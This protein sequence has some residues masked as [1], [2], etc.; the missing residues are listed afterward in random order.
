MNGDRRAARWIAAL[1]AAVLA[2]CAGA[3]PAAAPVSPL[4]P[5]Q[6][7]PASRAWLPLVMGRGHTAQCW[8]LD[9]WQ[10]EPPAVQAGRAGEGGCG[11]I[12]WTPSPLPE[13][14]WPAC[15]SVEECER[16]NAQAIAKARPG[17]VVLLL[18]EPNNPDTAGGGWPISPATA[19][20]RLALV[21]ERL[22]AAGLKAACCGLYFDARDTLGAADW[23]K[24]YTAAG[25]LSDLR[26]Y[27]I[28]G[29]TAGDA[30]AARARAARAMPGPWVISEA[31]WCESVKQALRRIEDRR[32][33]AVFVLRAWHCK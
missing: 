8:A 4:A 30:A 25:G 22:H 18:N 5:G 16:L 12:W 26:H 15:R 23:W 10:G 13:G 19:A 29:R 14:M 11:H 17:G 6:R 3:Q 7:T 21:V 33:P 2:G 24:R 27:H 28:F 1:C 31:G 32:Y 20:K 9:G